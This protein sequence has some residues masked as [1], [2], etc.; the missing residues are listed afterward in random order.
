[1]AGLVKMSYQENNLLWWF[2]NH[3]ATLQFVD[4]YYTNFY[5]N[6]ILV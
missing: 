3:P 1:M 5:K 2:L 4:K 6:K